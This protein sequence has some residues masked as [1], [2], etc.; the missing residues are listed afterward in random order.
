[1]A[2]LVRAKLGRTHFS[3]DPSLLSDYSSSPKKRRNTWTKNGNQSIKEE[4][5]LL[6]S[7]HSLLS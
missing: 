3:Q 5:L 1:M 6:I 2:P 7:D 4:G